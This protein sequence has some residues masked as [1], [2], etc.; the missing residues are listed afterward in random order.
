MS[1]TLQG[2]TRTA[3]DRRFVPRVPIAGRVWLIDSAGIPIV[4][5]DFAD[6]SPSGICLRV[7]VGFGV[8]EGR[9]YELRVA[10]PTARPSA[11]GLQTSR[12]AR[13][14]RTRLSFE[15]GEGI[16]EVGMAYEPAPAAKPLPS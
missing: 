11:F 2:T 14:V 15:T 8:A 13:V 16:L 5:C 9:R 6:A 3:T 4:Q 12:W 10:H 1:T 7:P